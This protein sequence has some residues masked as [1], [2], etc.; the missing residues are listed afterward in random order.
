MF[1]FF[2]KRKLKW[3][4]EMIL[5]EERNWDGAAYLYLIF[6]YQIFAFTLFKAQIKRKV[7]KST[8]TLIKEKC[9]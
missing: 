7:S 3:D 8:E 1:L 2:S 9:N 4:E 5:L 6:C